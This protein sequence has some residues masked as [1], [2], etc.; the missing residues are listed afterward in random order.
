MSRPFERHKGTMITSMAEVV[1]EEYKK[2]GCVVTCYQNCSIDCIC[3]CQIHRGDEETKE[4]L[5]TGVLKQFTGGD[6]VYARDL[7]TKT[8]TCR[9]VIECKDDVVFDD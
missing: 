2:A 6:C 3:E 9:Q 1:P 5:S 7:G 8:I 4:L